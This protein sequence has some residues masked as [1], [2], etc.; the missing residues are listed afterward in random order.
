MEPPSRAARGVRAARSARGARDG[1]SAAPGVGR[2]GEPV[3]PA[4]RLAGAVLGVA[5]IAT[6][7][8]GLVTYGWLGH[9]TAQPSTVVGDPAAGAWACAIGDDRPATRVS[10]LTTAVPQVVPEGAP[11]GS[12]EGRAAF[13]TVAGERE[14]IRVVPL[15]PG[16]HVAVAVGVEEGA[17]QW[18][19][20]ADLPVTAWR[21]WEVS[22]SPDLPGGRVAG[23]CPAPGAA[24]WVLPGLATDGGNESR[25]VVTN[26]FDSDATVAVRFVTTDGPLEPL[27]LR[28]VSVPGATTR[29][30]VVNEHVPQR[31]DV[32]AVVTVGAGR[33]AVEGYRTARAA[34]GGVRGIG[35]VQAS[36]EAAE[37]STVPWVREGGEASADLWLM[38][39]GARDADEVEVTVHTAAGGQSVAVDDDLRVPAGA[40]VRV[41]LAGALPIGI[42]QGAVTVRSD[43]APLHVA[44]S[45]VVRG[46]EPAATGIA[47][48][49]GQRED[50]DRWV[51][52]GTT[53]A[54]RD[55]ALVIVNRSSEDAVVVV[56]LDA[57]SAS[58]TSL[59]RQQSLLAT[60]V[61]VP[62]GGV[63]R[64]PVTTSADDVTSWSASVVAV[65]GRVVVARVGTGGESLDLVAVPGIPSWA[66]SPPV[67]DLTSRPRDGLGRR[68]GTAAGVALRRPIAPDL[69]VG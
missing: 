22:G 38:N 31:G 23:G 56:G 66:W 2:R 3:A 67:A 30:I 63:V 54:G 44:V 33:V 32:A 48:V 15:A 50:D 42:A 8:D 13:S 64:L 25:V 60:A 24:T 21:E 49:A 46:A 37:V 34:I 7:L 29:E 36:T 55:E 16:K 61:D 27:A 6:A 28:N 11:A 20:W 12:V 62:A 43:A 14:A 52:S 40:L 1:R 35:I 4:V 18:V 59:V 39:P 47:T 53:L 17:G 45:V 26:P 41:P 68:L 57:V 58:D 5:L 51:V 10:V 19:G 69:P 65:V 9:T